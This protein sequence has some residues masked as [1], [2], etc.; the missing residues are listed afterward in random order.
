MESRPATL[1]EYL[2]ANGHSLTHSRQQVFNALADSDALSMSQLT[3]K[4]QSKMDRASIYRNIELFEKLGII[5]R[6]QIGWKYKLELSDTFAEHHHHATC[7]Q[8]ESVISFEE[9]IEFESKISQLASSLNFALH[10][11]S[12]E[13]RGL[14]QKCQDT[15]L[16]T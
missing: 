14:C 2:S 16:N 10:S 1:K 4:L 3:R 12:I 5:N 6:I 7:S 9:D 11:H 8:C 15:N 13:L